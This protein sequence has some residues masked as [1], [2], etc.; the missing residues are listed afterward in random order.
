MSPPTHTDRDDAPT[1]DSLSDP[2]TS[3]ELSLLTRLTVS[4]RLAAEWTALSV[5]GFVTALFVFGGL[6]ASLTGQADALSV[7]LDSGTP[8]ELV[9]PGLL[10]VGLMVGVIVVHEFVHGMMMKRYGGS[11]NYG[12]GVTQFVLPY[13]YAT[14]ERPFTRNQFV[15]V[16][17]APL[18]VL[19]AAIFTLAVAFRWSILLLPLAL[20][21]GGAVGDLWMARL[22]L[23]YPETVRVVDETTGLA[24]YGERGVDSPSHASR[25][26]L[27]ASLVGFGM[28]IGVA[29]LGMMFAPVLLELSG[30]TSLSVGPPD[31]L[32]SLYQ[33]ETS[34][35]G[36]SS[37]VGFVG[38]LGVS[39]VVGLCYALVST[40]GT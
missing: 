24:I 26:F 13:A 15:V 31:S 34:S 33:F 4:R 29:F 3:N 2:D 25:G 11:P 28:G 12:F 35:E 22:L 5:A 7:R 21:V 37:E 39:A 9:G 10:S 32:W 1:T 36:V 23:R 16:A 8:W 17:L 20:N 40:S 19:T 18:V 38:I 14:T 27:R 6:Y 30:V